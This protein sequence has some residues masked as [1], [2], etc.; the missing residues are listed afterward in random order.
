MPKDAGQA[1]NIEPVPCR[2]NSESVAE[3]M[4][5]NPTFDADPPAEVPEVLVCVVPFHPCPVVGVE[6]VV[7]RL[8]A[9]A[10]P[11]KAEE[12]LPQLC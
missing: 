11:K 9:L 1:V 4:W 12:M 10:C 8:F 7:P 6:H 3:G 5:M 2:V